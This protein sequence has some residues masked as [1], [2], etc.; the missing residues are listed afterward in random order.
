M[1][2][3]NVTPGTTPAAIIG[4]PQHVCEVMLQTGMIVLAVGT[5][6]EVVATV[7]HAVEH[8]EGFIE[9]EVQTPAPPYKVSAISVQPS[10]IIMIGEEHSVLDY[11]H[12]PDWAIGI[13]N[14]SGLN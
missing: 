4:E 1:L 12:Q 8:G 6:E 10:A 7:K 3:Q 13:S 11:G 2:P 9:L 14:P 5:R